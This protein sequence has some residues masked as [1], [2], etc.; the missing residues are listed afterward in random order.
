MT[1]VVVF[2][3]SGV[4]GQAQVIELVRAGHHPVA[5]SRS[6]KADLNVDG[7]PVETAAADFADRAGVAKALEGAEIVFLNLPSTAFQKAETILNGAHIIAEEIKKAPSVKLTVFNTSMPVP[8]ESHDIRAQDDR[9]TIR[10]DLRAQGLDVI[11]IQPVCYL[12]NLLEGWALPPIRDEHTLAYC[13]KPS[14]RANWISHIDVA[15]V[16]ISAMQ[17]PHLA[18]RNIPIGGPETVRLVELA[19]KLSRGWGV[20]LKCNNQTVSDFC[21]SMGAAMR[22]RATIDVDRI[23]SQMFRAYTWFNESPTDPF[24]VDM[25]AVQKELPLDK[26]LLTIEEWARIKPIPAK[27]AA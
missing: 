18:G 26:P 19:E 3:A 7:V 16:M 8:D 20:E 24:V 25:D 12:E 6:P 14:L 22:K 5:V 13:H 1:R 4:Q 17:R 23:I 2:G 10:A 27:P 21:D 15:K 9:R 11:S